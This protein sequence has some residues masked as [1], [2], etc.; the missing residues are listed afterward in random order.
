MNGLGKVE[1]GRWV[2]YCLVVAAAVLVALVIAAGAG[3]DVVGLLPYLLVPG[4]CILMHVFMHR[5]HSHRSEDH[6][7]G[8]A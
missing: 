6:T 8:G 7:K 4:V 1:Q 5:G 2:Q 3:I